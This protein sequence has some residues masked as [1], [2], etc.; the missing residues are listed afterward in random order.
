MRLIGHLAALPRLSNVVIPNRQL[1]PR[2]QSSLDLSFIDT[3]RP[4][5]RGVHCVGFNAIN[6]TAGFLETLLSFNSLQESSLHLIGSGMA[7]PVQHRPLRIATGDA[8][9]G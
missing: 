6:E 7:Q 4:S 8:D 5:L 9:H 2:T 3:D 1:L